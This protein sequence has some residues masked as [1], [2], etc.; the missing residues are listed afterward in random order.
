[1]PIGHRCGIDGYSKQGHCEGCWTTRLGLGGTMRLRGLTLG[2]AILAAIAL[3]MGTSQAADSTAVGCPSEKWMVSVFPLGW[4]S[5]DVMDPTGDNLLLQIAIT[6][7]IEEFGSLEAGLESFGFDTLEELYAAA[8]D[9]AFN[10]V[11]QNDDGVLCVKRFPEQG[12]GQPAY[13]A[14]AIDNHA[15]RR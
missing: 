13:F 7:F 14:N 10:K 5:G 4:Q 1:M 6:G 15:A 2:A 12:Q 11:D 3:P 9:P 8:I